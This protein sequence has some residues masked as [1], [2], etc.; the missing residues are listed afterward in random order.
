MMD[1]S[2]GLLID[3]AR[4]AEA[5]GLRAAIDLSALPLGDAFVAERGDDLEAR[6]FAAT[7][8]DDYALLAADR[9][10][11]PL[12]LSLPSG[13]QSTAI[14]RLERG[15]GLSFRFERCR[16]AGPGAARP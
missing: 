10:T 16:D 15:E 14:G 2:D 7:G 1:V 6:L 13:R 4:L 3:C 9:R 8:G 11:D 12:G 5:S